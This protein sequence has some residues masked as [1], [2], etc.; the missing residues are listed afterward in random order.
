MSGVSDGTIYL[1][2]LTRSSL[3]E[4]DLG[5]ILFGLIEELAPAWRPG[6]WGEAEPARERWDPGRPDRAWAKDELRVESAE[7]GTAVLEVEKRRPGLGT[8]GSVRVRARPD[9]IDPDGAARLFRKLATGLDADYGHLHLAATED[10]GELYG[11]LGHQGRA[12]VSIPDWS[13]HLFLPGVFWAMVLGRSYTELFGAE[14]IRS[15]PAESVE[16]L[17]PGRW[18]LQLTPSLRDNVTDREK[19]VAAREAVL[20]HLGRDAFWRPELGQP[21]Y[22]R[23]GRPNPPGRAPTF[24]DLR[25]AVAT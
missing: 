25:S 23:H 18:Y 15:C 12:L 24:D 5:G 21:I 7:G 10:I 17:D 9:S 19:V 13:L 22:P 8:H 1:Q 11:V 2:L 20:D 14:A 6:R 4:P 3:K 16:E